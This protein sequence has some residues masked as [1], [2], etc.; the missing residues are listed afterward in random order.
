M[1]RLKIGSHEI[2]DGKP[3]F[4]VAEIGV[5]HNGD[6]AT[7][8]YM[9]DKAARCGADAVKFQKRTPSL[10]LTREA[11]DAPYINERSFG[12][13]YGLHRAALELPDPAWP[14]LKRLAESKKVALYATPYDCESADFL[15]DLGVP[16]IKIAS[17]DVTN[18][19]LLEHVARLGVPIILSTGMSEEQEIDHAVRLLWRQTQDIV[20]MNCCSAYPAEPKDLNLRYMLKLRKNYQTLVGHSGHEQGLATSFAAVALGASVLER[21]LT[22]DKSSRGP[23]H[24]ASLEPAEFTALVRGVRDIEAAMTEHPK[25]VKKAEQ[26]VRARLA[27]SLVTAR[28]ISAGDVIERSAIC[29]KGPGTGLSPLL[30]DQVIGHHATRAI[31]ADVL[32]REDMFR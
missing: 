21:H 15:A 9:I 19:I 5:C 18:T 6:P 27:K 7:A 31:P 25:R 2:G 11:L 30:M 24:A 12:E 28:P 20:L 29:L 13:T 10:I 26:P 17:C 16:A 3:C 1:K 4:I 32:L 22:L 23:D 14:V 8:A